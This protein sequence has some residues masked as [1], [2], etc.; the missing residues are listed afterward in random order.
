MC[1]DMLS[2]VLVIRQIFPTSVD[3]A[4]P[5]YR[6]ISTDAAT[7]KQQIKFNDYANE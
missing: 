6:H 2:Q 4:D 3:I 7:L 1:Q 5:A